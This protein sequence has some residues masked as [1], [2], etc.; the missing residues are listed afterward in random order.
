MRMSCMFDWPSTPTSISPP[1]TM[2][3]RRTVAAAVLSAAGLYACYK[4]IRSRSSNRPPQEGWL[5]FIGCAV[6]FG[7][8]P[9]LF[10]KRCIDKVPCVS[11]RTALVSAHTAWLGVH[12]LCCRQEDDL[13]LGSRALRYRVQRG[14]TAALLCPRLTS[15]GARHQLPGRRPALHLPCGFV[16]VLL[17]T[18]FLCSP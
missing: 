1:H 10:I 7:K 13:P 11:H 4:Y 3:D 9:L 12:H 15:I 16:T 5:P 17:I 8:A 14:S 2:M 18:C 6:Q